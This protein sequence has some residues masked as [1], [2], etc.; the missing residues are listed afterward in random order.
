M[1]RRNIWPSFTG[2]ARSAAL[3]HPPRRQ[4]AATRYGIHPLYLNPRRNGQ[5]QFPVLPDSGK[6][7][8]HDL[9]CRVR[10]AGFR[11]PVNR[12]SNMDQFKQEALRN[13]TRKLPDGSTETTYEVLP[14]R[15]GAIAGAGIG[16]TVGSIIPGIGTAVGAGVGAAVG[17]LI[18]F[19]FGPA[20]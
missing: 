1:T 8:D 6:L 12:E 18:G 2:S 19:I 20:D 10:H 4:S 14:S 7:A 5:V 9:A 15:S 17:G 13:K 11:Y 3:H 16:A